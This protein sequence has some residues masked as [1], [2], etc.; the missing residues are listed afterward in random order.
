M[1]ALKLAGYSPSESVRYFDIVS[2]VFYYEMRQGGPI[3]NHMAV[4]MV[5]CTKAHWGK[6]S[7]VDSVYELS[8]LFCPELGVSFDI[9]GKLTSG[10]QSSFTLYVQPCN[11]DYSDIPCATS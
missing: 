1:F 2:Y 11:P 10:K 9:F 3:A 5:P 8:G 7:T 6:F 4:N